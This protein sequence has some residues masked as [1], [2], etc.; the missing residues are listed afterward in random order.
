[1]AYKLSRLIQD[2]K[3]HEC[4]SDSHFPVSEKSMTDE[5][6]NDSV[7]ENE[8]SYSIRESLSKLFA[9]RNFTIFLGTAWVT[10]TFTYMSLYFTIYLRVIG[11][12]YILMG[13]VLSVVSAVEAI[14]RLLG[15]YLGD[16]TQRKTMAVAAFLMIGTY[17]LL[18]GIFVDPIMI[19][20]ALLVYALFN[21][22]KSGSSAFFMESI[23]KE[24]GGLGIGLFNT[25]KIFGIITLLAFGIIIPIFGFPESFRLVYLTAGILV[26]FCSLLR[27]VYLEP[28]EVNSRNKD[29]TIWKDFVKENK[30]AFQLLL[31]SAPGLLTV[32]ILDSL[33]D[34]IYRFA[35][36]VYTYEVLEIDI[37]G[38]N[39][40]LIFTLIISVPLMLKVGRLTDEKGVKRGALIVYSMMPISALLL[41]LAQS[42]LYWAPQS[43][44]S[45]L[46]AIV[47]GLG[48]VFTLPFIA[49]VIKY[50]NDALWWMVV[51]I[52]IRKGLPEEDTAK[53]LSIFWVV[54]Y[55]ASSIGPFIGAVIFELLT[56]SLLFFTV[57]LLNLAILAAI[58]F[59]DF[60]TNGEILQDLKKTQ[61]ESGD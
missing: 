45:A 44:S 51:L 29:E 46:N 13:I 21:I 38:I 20:G 57:I 39:M 34:N 7:I 6:P 27:A 49:I 8:P 22:A 36:L 19:T 54:V 1:M 24:H 15:G 32:V 50:V 61:P 30:R 9:S 10:N 3:K 42:V 48:V 16:I 43:W 47:P 55:V 26:F 58:G 23:P 37:L 25:G 41:I 2:S 14:S 40:I 60:G 12:D 52:L 28:C 59:R 35:A 33:S 31:A 11:W 4:E 5:E 17:Y 18:M 53:I 56:P